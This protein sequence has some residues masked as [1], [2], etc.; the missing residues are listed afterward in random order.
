MFDN[1]FK[2]YAA[3]TW[4]CLPK[5]VNTEKTLVSFKSKLDGFLLTVQ[6][7]PPVAG[8]STANKNRLL[9]WLASANAY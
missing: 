1:S 7:C 2:V 4:N 9:D 5:S 3:K 6:D 8:Y